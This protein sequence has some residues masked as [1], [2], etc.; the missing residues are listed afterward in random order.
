MSKSKRTEPT[1]RVID[2]LRFL[3]EIQS[4]TQPVNTMD[5]GP[6]TP[7]LNPV[8]ALAPASQDGD[9]MSVEV[10]HGGEDEIDTEEISK[11]IDAFNMERENVEL[12]KEPPQWVEDQ[13]KWA[14]AKE[15]SQSAFNEFRWSFIT[16]YYLNM[17]SQEVET[18]VDFETDV[19]PDAEADIDPSIL[20]G[21]E[22]T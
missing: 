20:A 19:E 14:K 10:E 21:E 11:A 22:R 7:D 1:T 13:S 16:W 17:E 18:P 4:T 3:E 15:A 5:G 12:D 6:T 8:D 2:M 9:K